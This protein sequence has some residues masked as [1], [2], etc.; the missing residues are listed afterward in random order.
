M[1]PFNKE[2]QKGL[3]WFEVGISLISLHYGLGFLLG[4]GS[5]VFLRGPL[6]ILYALSASLGLF[7]LVL[8]AKYFWIT[9]KPIWELMG[10]RFGPEVRDLVAFLSGIWMLGVVASQILGGA[11]AMSIF[12]ISKT[13]STIFL[14]V[15]I[16]LT[17]Y[18][19]IGKLGKVLTIMLLLS[20]ALLISVLFSK[21][22]H[23][24]PTATYDFFSNLQ[25]V[26]FDDVFGIIVTTVLVTFIGMDFHQFIVAGRNY[27]DSIKG[28]IFGGLVTALL[29]LLILALVEACLTDGVLKNVANPAQVIP[30][31]LFGFGNKFNFA[32]GLL[33]ALPILL[34]AIG[35]G[36]CVVRIVGKTLTDF[37]F[38]KNIANQPK[39][40]NFIVVI[41]AAI[42]AITGN[43]IIDIIVSFYA[44]YV[45]SVFIPFVAFLIDSKWEKIIFSALEI[46]MSIL[47]PAI[48]SIIILILDGVTN[49]DFKFSTSTIILVA[50]FSSS[51]LTLAYYKVA[52]PKN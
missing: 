47:I 27:K 18:I 11:Y 29:A 4:S 44:V 9:K 42:L 5:A 17:S 49:L 38:T 32:V 2:N 15:S 13:A 23:W 24:V 6:G 48:F 30:L 7:S 26:N 21:G 35:S 46:K 3:T 22:L 39:V 10:D 36:S 1:S 28:S 19:R 25:N 14:L 34:V 41:I 20:S 16:L 43:S 33:L 51:F 45:S 50:G 8:I 31:I 52:V 12:G 40:A 37:S